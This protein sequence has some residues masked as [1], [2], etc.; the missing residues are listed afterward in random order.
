MQLRKHWRFSVR[1]TVVTLF[2]VVCSIVAAL[3][4]SLRY[5]NSITQLERQTVRPFNQ[6][7]TRVKQTIHQNDLAASRMVDIDISQFFMAADSQNKVVS[8]AC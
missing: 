3:T 2:S 1:I 5:Y 6:F 8:M 7:A 4:V